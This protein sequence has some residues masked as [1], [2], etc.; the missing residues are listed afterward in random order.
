MAWSNGSTRP[1]Y[2]SLYKRELRVKQKRSRNRTENGKRTNVTSPRFV[3]SI[4]YWGEGEYSTVVSFSTSCSPLL[5]RKRQC[6]RGKRQKEERVL[7]TG[8][9]FSDLSVTMLELVLYI[10][11]KRWRL[12]AVFMD[13]RAKISIEFFLKILPL[14]DDELVMSEM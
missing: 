13:V 10:Y 7:Y 9:C 11:S 14:K 6:F 2:S 1:K 3:N 4:L 5:L 8:S 12:L